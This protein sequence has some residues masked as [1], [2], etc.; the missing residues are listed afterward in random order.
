MK[1]ALKLL[2]VKNFKAFFSGRDDWI[3][4]CD[5]VVANDVPRW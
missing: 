4:T 3:R 1:K 5:P 2:S